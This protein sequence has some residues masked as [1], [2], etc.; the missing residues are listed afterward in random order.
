MCSLFAGLFAL[1]LPPGAHCLPC[2]VMTPRL[3][4]CSESFP[5]TPI[6]CTTR[7][8]C[9]GCTRT[10]PT[11]H[12]YS[13]KHLN[14]VPC[15]LTELS[16]LGSLELS[17]S[18]PPP[19]LS[20]QRASSSIAFVNERSPHFVPTSSLPRRSDAQL[21]PGRQQAGRRL[22]GC[23]GDAT[24]TLPQRAESIPWRNRSSGTGSSRRRSCSWRRTAAVTGRS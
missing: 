14:L 10:I 7:S 23:R 16:P 15:A 5:H 19:P 18:S 11:P 22:S 6:N 24:A 2:A 17:P 9:N 21:P 20:F 1:L 8:T 3:H 4:V 13:R 12:F